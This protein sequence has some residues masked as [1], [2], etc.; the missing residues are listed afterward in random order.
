LELSSDKSDEILDEI[1]VDSNGNQ[2]ESN[3]GSN[4]E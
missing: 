1:Q 3:I 4:V 2:E